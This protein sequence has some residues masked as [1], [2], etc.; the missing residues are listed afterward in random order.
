MVK[1][2][3][4]NYPRPQF[5][6]KQWQSLNGTWDFVFDESNVGEKLRYYKTFPVSHKK[7]NVPYSYETA[8][9]GI[10]DESEHNVVWY[11]RAL[12]VPELK[13][14]QRYVI[15][16]EGVDYTAKVWVNGV[17]AGAHQGG[18]CRFS[19]DVTDCLALDQSNEVVV[20]CE[21]SSDTAQPRGKQRWL[22]ES[23]GCWYVQTTGIWKPV[24]SEIVQ[25]VRLERL[26]ITPFVDTQ[27]VQFE[28][29]IV[30][31]TNNTEVETAIYFDG[32]LIAKS[33]VSAVRRNFTAQ[34]DLRSDAMDFKVKLWHPVDPCLYDVVVSVIENGI[35]T[36]TV[37]SYFGMRKVEADEKGIRL[38][39]SPLYQKLIL[40]QNYWKDSGY[41]MADEKT[42]E[43]DIRLAL[44]AGFN[45][46]RIHQ[47]IE[48]ERFLYL[49]D[50]YGVLVWAE[51]P[52]TYEF[53]DV[54]VGRLTSEW[55]EA[56]A[57]QYNHPCVITW[58]PFNESWGIPCI[59][60]NPAQQNFTRA[61]YELTKT[62]DPY[63]PVIT[64]DG[65]EHTSCSDIITLHDYDGCGAAMAKRYTDKMAGILNNEI[66]HG[67]YKFAFAKGNAYRH[68]PVIV[69]EYG[70]AAFAESEGWGYD[71][72]VKNSEE[73]IAKFAELTSVW[74][75]IPN[76][77]GYCY[78]QLTDVYQE[79]NGIADME[80]V[81][82]ADLKKIKEI[83]DNRF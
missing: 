61:V 2:Y 70:G 81:P 39:N 46:M 16:F 62:Y 67:Q 74:K 41:T 77:S 60:D 24:W 55:T 82:K 29:D 5:V 30:G 69:S 80:R 32:T 54:A 11:R 3:Q 83:N 25:S 43:T 45:G 78:T 17:F 12:K 14:G 21:D 71:G 22:K 76:L 63:R 66:A 53:S 47:K 23:F 37:G 26:K 59:S 73:F 27:S 33:R 40:A 51:F 7:I 50:V 20:R 42:A 79:T 6:R 10:G 9:S 58:V 57:Q 48:D 28:Y 15:N 35:V 75:S 18:Y 38:N 34:Y 1:C 31:A 68:Q 52:S 13:D 65:W 49:C 4:E 8:R 56:L 36:D 64:N 72:R 19:V 44:D